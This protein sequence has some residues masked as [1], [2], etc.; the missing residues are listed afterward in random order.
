MHKAS[1]FEEQTKNMVMYMGMRKSVKGEGY[2][3]RFYI[4]IHTHLHDKDCQ[5]IPN[6]IDQSDQ[7]PKMTDSKNIQAIF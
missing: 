3:C 4:M 7:S 6:Y 1:Q 5:E 2:L